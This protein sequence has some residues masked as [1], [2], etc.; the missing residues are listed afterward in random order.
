[1]TAIK[2]PF[3]GNAR[4][5]LPNLLPTGVPNRFPLSRSPSE[6]DETLSSLPST[7]TSRRSNDEAV[8]RGNVDIVANRNMS[9]LKHLCRKTQPLSP[10]FWI[11][12][13][14]SV[15]PVDIRSIAKKECCV[16]S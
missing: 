3:F 7:N 6:R 16:K 15:P 14:R 8:L 5:H 1:M 2:S 10:H 4:L 11:F 9:V 13:T 12:V